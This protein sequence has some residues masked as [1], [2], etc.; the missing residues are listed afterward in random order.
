MSQD[1]CRLAVFLSGTG[2]T[3]VNLHD[4]ITRGELPAE[5]AVVISSRSKALG[6]ERAAERGI[7]TRVLPRRPFLKGGE[8]DAPGYS[9][10]LVQLVDPF[11]PDLIILAGF[12]TRLAEP[13][14]GRYDVMNVH[15]ALLPLFGGEGYFGHRVHEAVLRAGV[16]ITGATVHFC[17]ADYDCGPIIAQEA[18][19]V[20]ENDDPDTL[21]ARVQAAERRIYPRAVALYARGLLKREQGRVRVLEG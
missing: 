11:A 13:L 16:K 8:F 20:H 12:M 1:P 9:R 3:M 5:I 17:D 6:L 2:T 4:Y 14:L 7:P 19:P 18:V 10:A 21:A 15:P